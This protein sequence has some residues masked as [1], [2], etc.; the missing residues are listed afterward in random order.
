MLRY[1]KHRLKKTT[2]FRPNCKGW[3]AKPDATLVWLFKQCLSLAIL[4]YCGS[5]GRLHQIGKHAKRR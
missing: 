3:G 4:I 5:F 2:N 1:L